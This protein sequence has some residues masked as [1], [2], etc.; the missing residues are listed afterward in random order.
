MLLASI[1][2]G[3]GDLVRKATR[4][5][6][7][8]AFALKWSRFERARLRRW[9]LLEIRL[10][11]EKTLQQVKHVK[12]PEVHWGLEVRL[13]ENSQNV[14][15]HCPS[16]WKLQ[17]IQALEEN[18]TGEA[19]SEN[20]LFE[21]NELENTLQVTIR[22]RFIYTVKM[23]E[24]ALQGIQEALGQLVLNQGSQQWGKLVK[25]PETFKPTNR[26]EELQ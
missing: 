16:S 9:H 5:D 15:V 19:R 7:V 21:P 23:A 4:T 6:L 20:Y 13:V 11:S 12:D 18:S 22:Q 8:Q 17:K 10:S 2:G 1:S 14:E 26:A 25:T 24:N 3:A